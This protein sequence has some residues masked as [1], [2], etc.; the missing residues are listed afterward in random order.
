M[1]AS[2]NETESAGEHFHATPAQSDRILITFGLPR[3]MVG[4]AGHTFPVHL[5]DLYRV[6]NALQNEVCH[7]MDRGR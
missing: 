3:V 6:A 5:F 2:D 4:A 1:R 7:L